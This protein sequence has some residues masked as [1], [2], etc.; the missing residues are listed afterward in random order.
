[1]TTKPLIHFAHANGVPSKSYQKLFAALADSF[2]IVYVP[3]LGTHPAFPVDNHW[4]SLTQ[5]VIHSIQT[6][7]NGR[8]VIGLGHSL[9]ALL[10]FQASYQ[11]PDLFSQVV[12]MDPPLIYGKAAFMWHM[13]K[14]LS[15]S[16]VDSM[17]PA[18]LSGRRRDFW[19]NRVVAANQLRSKK[20]F[21]VFDGDCFADYIQYGLLNLSE[22]GVTLTI[23][24][25]IEADIFRTNPSLYWLTPN[26]APKVPVIQLS[27]SNSQF[28]KR[29]FP[30][31]L[32]KR[33]GIPFVLQ[34]GGHMFPL[35]SPLAVA[36][37]LKEIIAKNK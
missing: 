32:Q 28:I 36:K 27:G 29:G 21:R 31:A 13:V 6:Q 8:K 14:L 30:Q 12:M 23:P 17:T 7:A 34:T 1:M 20:F 24:K 26:H 15:P 35:E 22:G 18:G 10:T 33:L 5:Q 3:V 37:T 25:A 11:R 19:Q 9:G 2:D 16:R 4:Q